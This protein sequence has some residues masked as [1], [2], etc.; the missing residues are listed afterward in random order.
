MSLS[1]DSC[2][3]MKE[4]LLDSLRNG[5]GE[6][7]SEAPVDDGNGDPK[8]CT[9]LAHERWAL[10]PPLD[11]FDVENLEADVAVKVRQRVVN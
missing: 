6:N 10:E 8:H 11:D 4:S 9:L 1:S 3:Q 7:E 2:P 5:R